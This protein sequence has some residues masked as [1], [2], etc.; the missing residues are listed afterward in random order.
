MYIY[1]PK[2]VTQPSRALSD[3]ILPVIYIVNALKT[4]YYIVIM[5]D[6]FDLHNINNGMQKVIN[7]TD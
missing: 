1:F 4:L 2:G 6:I 7:A 3:T 5:V